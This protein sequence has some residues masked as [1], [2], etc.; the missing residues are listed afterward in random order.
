MDDD[1]KRLEIG[2]DPKHDTQDDPKQDV[3]PTEELSDEQLDNVAG[4]FVI[5]WQPA[6]TAPQV[7][8]PTEFRG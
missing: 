8:P 4:G 7:S 5:N 1:R 2:T 3:N 6:P